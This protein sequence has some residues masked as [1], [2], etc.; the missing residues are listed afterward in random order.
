MLCPPWIEMSKQFTTTY[1][2]PTNPPPPQTCL[3]PP[4]IG[5][6]NKPT[7]QF[8]RPSWP[9]K[10][11]PIW[12]T[13]TS[14][15]PL[16]I[17]TTTLSDHWWNPA[18]GRTWTCT[19]SSTA[20][21][22]MAPRSSQASVP[23]TGI[24]N[25]FHFHKLQQQKFSTV[26]GQWG[27]YNGG[28]YYTNTGDYYS[29]L[30]RWTL[31]LAFLY[32]SLVHKKPPLNLSFGSPTTFL[33]AFRSRLRLAEAKQEVVGENGSG[34]KLGGGGGGNEETFRWQASSG[35]SKPSVFPTLLLAVI[36]LLYWL[37]SLLSVPPFE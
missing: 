28:D 24:S 5:S 9:M 34:R 3:L 36:V 32:P 18:W 17:L 25:S 2:N 19:G 22:G 8:S 31:P 30:L 15:L 14:G 6:W 13:K 4:H 7:W 20:S 33:G 11:C 21:A 35:S 27:D 1:Q 23:L 37:H 26:A 10:P 16:W 12:T 29:R